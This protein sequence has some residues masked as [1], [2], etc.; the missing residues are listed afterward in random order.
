MPVAERPAAAPSRGAGSARGR[1]PILDF[2]AAN[3][4]KPDRAALLLLSAVLL[5]ACFILLLPLS[6]TVRRAGL[7]RF[8]LTRWPLAAWML[9]QPA[10]SMYNFE[11]RWEVVR[12]HADGACPRTTNGFVNH[13]VYN[14]IALFNWRVRFRQCPLPAWMH[15]RSA[16]RGTV[17]ETT[18]R[19]DSGPDQHGITVTPVTEP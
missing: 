1:L 4:E 18:Y 7:R 10:P 16:Y 17:V 12:P 15:F 6:E 13:H 19:L 5:F 8:Q 11:N 9:F 14:R 3:A 2:I